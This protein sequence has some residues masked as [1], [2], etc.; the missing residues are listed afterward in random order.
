MAQSGISACDTG[1]VILA[2]HAMLPG[3]GPAS[4]TAFS[5]ANETGTPATAGGYGFLYDSPGLSALTSFVGEMR[6]VAA[7][8][9]IS[10]YAPETQNSGM[11]FGYEGSAKNIVINTSAG[12]KS[13][14]FTLGQTAQ[15]VIFNGMTTGDTFSTYEV[16]INYPAADANWQT[17]RDMSRTAVAAGTY[18]GADAA[19]FDLSDMPVAVVGITG[20]TPG[21]RYLMDGAIVYE[22]QPK[23]TVGMSAPKRQ[24]TAS[25]SMLA[26]TGKL[27]QQVANKWGG[28][29]ISSAVNYA[30]GG[31]SGAVLALARQSYA[32]S[33]QSARVP[34]I[35]WN[36]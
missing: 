1:G 20:G 36:P 25:S 8:V 35:G 15:N 11:F 21:T 22:W 33:I 13:S 27:V 6:P 26:Q 19:E 10:C 31:G 30:T 34:R 4:L 14:Y 18:D 16:R 28:M 24:A 17:F 23:L 12:D 29:L 7:C 9:R 3:S 5:A 2:P 32:A